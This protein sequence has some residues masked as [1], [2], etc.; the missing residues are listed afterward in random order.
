MGEPENLMEGLQRE[1]KRNRELVK[2]YEA[3]GTAGNF[4]RA[5]ICRDIMEGEHAIADDDVVAM[6]RAYN[7]L[8][9]NK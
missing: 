7:K 3:I 5:F 9:E 2:E 6:L 4:G 1:L 8:K